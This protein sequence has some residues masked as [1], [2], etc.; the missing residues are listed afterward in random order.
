MTG[1]D[2]VQA[3]AEAAAH[4]AVERHDPAPRHFRIVVIVAGVVL[5]VSL[6][7]GS[8]YALLRINHLQGAADDNARIAQE[9]GDQVRDL[10]GTPRVQPPA[11]NDPDPEDPE[12]D[13]PERQE[14][15]IQDPE[16]QESET[17]DP[18]VDDPEVQD[19][20]IDDPDPDDPDPVIPGPPPAGWTWVDGDGRTQSCQRTG[21]PDTAPTYT[22]TASPPLDLHVTMAGADVRAR[23]DLAGRAGVAGRTGGGRRLGDR[24]RGGRRRWLEPQERDQGGS[25]QRQDGECSLHDVPLLTRLG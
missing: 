21:G 3:I 4:Q 19:P 7:F 23:D 15:E 24:G 17:Q 13:D 6:V 12:I 5:A 1:N 10:G 9:L 16:V 14:S 11:V 18:E 2:K 8:V 22:C 25:G 20:E